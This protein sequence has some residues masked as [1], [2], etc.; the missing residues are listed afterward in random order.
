VGLPSKNSSSK[1]GV[2]D[3]FKPSSRLS[4][5]SEHYSD[6]KYYSGDEDEPKH[7]EQEEIMEE[8]ENAEEDKRARMLMSKEEAENALFKRLF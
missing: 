3:S 7:D 4:K 2:G 8:G 5:P 1:S 6:D